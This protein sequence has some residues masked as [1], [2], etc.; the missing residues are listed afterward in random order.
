MK[1]LYDKLVNKVLKS[2]SLTRYERIE[3]SVEDIEPQ[4]RFTQPFI[5]ISRE[6]G[7]GGKPV[8]KLLAKWL[9]FE[10]YDKHLLTDLSR[11]VRRRKALLKK[12]DE[13]GRSAV[14]DIVQSM[15]NP[16]YISDYDYIGHLSSVVLT[17][18]LKGEVVILGRGA[19]FIT[20]FE[21]GLHV[22]ISAPYLTRVERAVEYEKISREEAIDV[23]K[24][25]DADRRAYI[26][27]YF[28]KDIA[29]SNYYDLV[30]N[31]KKMNIRD[32]A[33]HV[34]L[35]LKNKFPEYAKKRRKL[36]SK[37]LLTF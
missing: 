32:T 34:A 1:N 23:I 11:S 28:N 9:K 14:E 26:S 16:E 20:P 8:A 25:I 31:T 2:Y 36:F 18:A 10:F 15:F 29:R 13:K 5:T 4:E 35:A 27:Q 7:S 37:L 6:P 22:R 12:I 30:I 21:K 33:E 17:A 3:S 24:K 19:N